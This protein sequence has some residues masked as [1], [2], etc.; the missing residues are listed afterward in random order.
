MSVGC[1]QISFGPGPVSGLTLTP[2]GR[3]LLSIPQTTQ[4]AP[5]GA[6]RPCSCMLSF[7]LAWSGQ[8]TRTARRTQSCQSLEPASSSSAQSDTDSLPRRSWSTHSTGWSPTFMR[9]C[10]E[11]RNKA[12]HSSECGMLSGRWGKDWTSWYKPLMGFSLLALPATMC[13]WE[14]QSHCQQQGDFIGPLLLFVEITVSP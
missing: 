6:H 5:I 14:L 13:T 12:R 10:K 4:R 2:G 8:L 9:D 11:G 3:P 1:R 7:P